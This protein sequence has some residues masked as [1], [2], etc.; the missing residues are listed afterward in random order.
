MSLPT[1]GYSGT[2]L[3]KKLGIKP[4]MQAAI[5]NPP[6]NYFAETLGPLPDGV[7]LHRLLQPDLDFI[8]F[9][10]LRSR[11]LAVE[12]PELKAAL[13]QDGMLWISWPKKAAK[14][15][16]DLDE[17]LVRQIGLDNGLVDVKV[18]AVDA[19]W[20]GLKFV[21]RLADRKP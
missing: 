3:I 15:P 8:H 13:A 21:F 6:E 19:V 7:T 2:P 20:S 10:S 17:N 18:A 11:Q 4:G 1:H 12:F 5:L 9:F 14:V 16:S